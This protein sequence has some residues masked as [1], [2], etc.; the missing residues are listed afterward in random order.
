MGTIF[1][2]NH[3]QG[4]MVGHLEELSLSD[5]RKEGRLEDFIRQREAAGVGPVREGD[6]LSAAAKI[7][8]HEPRSNRTSR[9]ASRG[10]S[11]GK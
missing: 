10:G 6:F 3:Y 2:F 5:A 1:P 11:S 9:S 7:I 8:K 4:T